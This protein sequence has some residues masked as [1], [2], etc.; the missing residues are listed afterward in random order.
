[1]CSAIIYSSRLVDAPEV[2]AKVLCLFSMT[3][4]ILI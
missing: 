1:V 2:F 4:L 3:S